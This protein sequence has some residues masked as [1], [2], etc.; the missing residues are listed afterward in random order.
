MLNRQATK[1]ERERETF[2]VSKIRAKVA[3]HTTSNSLAVTWQIEKSFSMSKGCQR[4]AEKNRKCVVTASCIV[5]G[6]SLA[7]Q[8]RVAYK[9]FRIRLKNRA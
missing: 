1:R 3:F 5:C 7:E 4:D 6:Y 9:R 8:Y 2:G